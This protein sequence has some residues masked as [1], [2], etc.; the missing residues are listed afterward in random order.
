[1]AQ[2]SNIPWLAKDVKL[3]AYVK[4]DTQQELAEMSEAKKLEE[5]PAIDMRDH[6]LCTLQ[7]FLAGKTKYVS[8]ATDPRIPYGTP[9]RI[10][11]LEDLYDRVID[12]RVVDTGS[13][14]TGKGFTRMDICVDTE[15]ESLA[16][17]LN[18]QTLVLF[19][20]NTQAEGKDPA[21]SEAV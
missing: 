15:A 19:R 11:H 6:P 13:A 2:P 9:V 18:T 8:V 5:G 20:L 17:E 3:T 10:P 7:A 12:F 4:V 1:M 21:K 16:E 14:F